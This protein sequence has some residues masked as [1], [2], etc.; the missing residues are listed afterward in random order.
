M[1]VTDEMEA[2]LSNGRVWF[3]DVLSNSEQEMDVGVERFTFGFTVRDS[4]DFFINV[5]AWGNEAYIIGLSSNFSIGHCVKDSRDFY[6]LGDILAN[7]QSLD[8]TIINILAAVKSIGE[9]KYFTTSDRRNGHRLE[10]KLFDDSVSTFPLVCWDKEAI[11]LIQKV[12]P[13]ET[14]LF[15][16]DAKIG[17]DSFRNGMTATV[18]SKTIITVNP[19]T[20]EAGLLF[21]YAKE[22]SESGCLDQDESLEDETV[23][24]ITNVYT[25]R[26]LKKKAQEN[27]E[28]FFGITYSFVSK[29]DLDSSLSRVIS[30][31]CKFVVGEDLLSCSNELCPGKGQVFSAVTGFDLLVDL[32]DHTG[33]LQSCSLR[34]P[35]AET[36]L[37]CTTEE[38]T[39]LTD[40]QRTTMKWKFLL[41]RCKVY[42][43]IIPSTKVKA[44]IRGTVL[45][46]SLADPGE[47]H[48]CLAQGSDSHQ[49]NMN[50]NQGTVG[51]DPVILATAGYDHTV[52]FWQAHSGICTRTVQHQDSQVNSLEVTPDRSMIAAAGYQHIRMY[53]LNSN[54][55]NP[56]INYDGVSK[57]ITSV[58]F[59]EDGRW[60]YT[61]GEDCLARIWDLR[62]RNLQCQKLFQVNAPI[63]C[64]CLHPNQAELI[65]GDQSGV[66]HI[67]DLK[68]D[69]N[70]QLIP[71]PEVSVNAVHIDPDASYM[72]AVNSSGNCYVWNMAGGIGEEVTQLIPKTKIPAHNRYSLRCKF[73]PDSTLLA[74]CSADQTCKIWRTSNFSLMTE[75]SIKSNN[76]GET[77]RGW[78]WD[79]AF[80]GDSQYIVTASSDNLARLWCVETGEIKREYSGHQK[81]VVCLAFNDSVLG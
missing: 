3:E 67:W 41:E 75:L 9:L 49:P 10:A 77:S 33:T 76:P 43:K 8:G 32:T 46:C 36:F 52:R 65:V 13:R 81:A 24:S 72:A 47:C 54:N 39:R 16:A 44:G 18:N 6:S 74:T 2:F 48:T 11:L 70:E 40:D 26:Q 31:R 29:L 19:D 66:I 73:S 60:M 53:D 42:V 61:G 1:G 57:N 20:R 71:E 35:A 27:P 34:S 7:G 59:H 51:S 37:G 38:F 15:I 5:T 62:S 17:F 28:T 4:H 23:D 80:S 12:I 56:V 45:A 64:V 22:V 50:V 58:G 25:M 21:S 78:M 69:H 55:P 14:V 68:T 79:C 30:S 63:N